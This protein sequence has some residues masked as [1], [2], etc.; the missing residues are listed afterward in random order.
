LPLNKQPSLKPLKYFLYTTPFKIIT[1][2]DLRV[3]KGYKDKRY[4]IKFIETLRAYIYIFKRF[5]GNS[6][7]LFSLFKTIYNYCF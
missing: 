7:N 4:K 3:I 6:I 2:L 5:K 1:I